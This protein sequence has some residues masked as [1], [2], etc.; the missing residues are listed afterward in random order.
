MALRVPG[1]EVRLYGVTMRALR[2]G[3]EWGQHD[4]AL[5]FSDCVEA[6]T[7]EQHAGSDRGSYKTRIGAA[8][9]IKRRGYSCLRDM[10]ADECPEIPVISARRGDGAYFEGPEGPFVAVVDGAYAVAPGPQGLLHVPLNQALT[11]FKVG[12]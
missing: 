10:I 4:C 5:F 11:A 3:H 2:R 12:D 1:W 6:V 8:R 7:G 9:I